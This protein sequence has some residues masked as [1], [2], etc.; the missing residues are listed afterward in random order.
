MAT[1]H[2]KHSCYT[3]RHTIH[4]YLAHRSWNIGPFL[5]HSLPKFWCALGVPFALPQLSLGIISQVFNGIKVKWFQAMPN[6]IFHGV[7]TKFWLS[8]LDTWGHYLA[9]MDKMTHYPP[10]LEIFWTSH[11]QLIEVVLK[12]PYMMYFIPQEKVHLFLSNQA[13][14]MPIFLLFAYKSCQNNGKQ[15]FCGLDCSGTNALHHVGNLQHY[16][17]Q[18]F[19]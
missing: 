10:L 6:H 11:E 9:R 17:N 1:I 19:M 14:K 5:L 4:K 7:I 3:L 15:M 8:Q 13:H 2:L 16:L 18:L 12:I